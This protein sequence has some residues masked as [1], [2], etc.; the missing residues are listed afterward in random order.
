ML[1]LY[2][3]STLFP[4]L[5]PPSPHDTKHSVFLQIFVYSI[6][7]LG[8]HAYLHHRILF[9]VSVVFS[10]RIHAFFFIRNLARA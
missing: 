7:L 1:I 3:V 9:K 4:S 10:L 8:V 2:A 5:V 6:A